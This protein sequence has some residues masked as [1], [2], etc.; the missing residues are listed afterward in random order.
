[1]LGISAHAQFRFRFRPKEK[2]KLWIS[3]SKEEI[4]E[5]IFILTG[6]RPARRPKRRPKT[7]Q[8]QLDMVF[9]GLTLLGTTADTFKIPDSP[10]KKY[11]MIGSSHE[12]VVWGYT[13]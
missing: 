1:M 3:L 11:K 8:K 13:F 4:E 12:E 10:P 5:D 6:S 2:A 9:P 7:V